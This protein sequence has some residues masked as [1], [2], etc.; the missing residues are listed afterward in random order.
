MWLSVSLYFYKWDLCEEVQERDTG[1]N[2]QGNE[3]D[4]QYDYEHNWNGPQGLPEKVWAGGELQ[5][6]V[7]WLYK[8]AEV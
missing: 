5:G 3:T 4:E 6:G 2:P 7:K 8:Q 1:V